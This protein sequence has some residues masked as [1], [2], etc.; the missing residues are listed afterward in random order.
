LRIG[1]VVKRTDCKYFPSGVNGACTYAILALHVLH[2]TQDASQRARETLH[3]GRLTMKTAILALALFTSVA[4]ASQLKST[5]G[6]IAG[7]PS[8]RS[9]T[10]SQGNHAM[11]MVMSVNP[12][13]RS[14]LAIGTLF[15]GAAAVFSLR[16]PTV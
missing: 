15:I 6:D 12:E 8:E 7:Q 1:S 11:S 13:F 16:R 14:L 9:F 10:E 4:H 3:G 2:P 5:G